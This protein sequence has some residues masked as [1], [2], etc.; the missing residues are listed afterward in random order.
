MDSSFKYKTKIQ[1]RFSDFD[2]LGHLNNATYLTYFET[3]RI[4]Y[5][6]EL[7][8]DIS[9]NQFPAAVVANF[10]VDFLQSVTPADNVEIWVR[11][12]RMGTKSLTIEY[13]IHSSD[14]QTVYC[15]A[16]SVL[17]CVDKTTG[18]TVELPQNG[19]ELIENFENQ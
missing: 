17:V 6:E 7:G 15:K 8:W 11:T 4:N 16:Q 18:K 5:F 12:G 2:M 14:K 9:S 1:P 19:R 13:E 10:H 3:S